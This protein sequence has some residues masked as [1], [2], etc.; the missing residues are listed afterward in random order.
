[1]NRHLKIVTFGGG[2]GQSQLLRG[3]ASW[4]NYAITA[5]CTPA[6]GGGDTGLI[7]TEYRKLGVNGSLGDI[8][9][10]LCALSPD[11]DLAEICM[12][13]FTEGTRAGQSVKNSIYLAACHRYGPEGALDFMHRMLKVRGN[14]TVMP[15]SFQ[16]TNLRVQLVSG[17]EISGEEY[18]DSISTN[19]LWKAEHHRIVDVGL[20][21]RVKAEQ[22]VINAIASADFILI[23]LG[24]LYTSVIPP[25]LASGVSRAIA[26]S[27]AKVIM[28]INLM[29][30][31]GETDGFGASDFVGEIRKRIRNRVPDVVICNN[32]GIPKELLDRYHKKEHK[33]AV[34]ADSLTGDDYRRTKLVRA[35]LWTE[36]QY[37]HIVHDPAK[38]AATLRKV[39]ATLKGT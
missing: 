22:N 20:Y 10:C 18:I 32:N 7:R 13:R 34:V 3:L 14:H 33:V 9:K 19:K 30:K 28:L 26:E 35:N 6:D 29:T 16:R 17:Q 21:P 15:A 25:L 1:M 24:D 27:K 36:D 5:I 8:G 12:H 31:I 2:G 23:G 37:G 4:K 38:T 39:F 11:R